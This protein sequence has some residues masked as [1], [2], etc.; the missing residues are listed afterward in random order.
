MTAWE[1]EVAELTVTGA[2]SRVIA[3]QLQISPRTVDAHLMRIYRKVGVASRTA[4]VS[5][6]ARG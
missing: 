1:R 3:R 2:T 6:L 5:L 4:L